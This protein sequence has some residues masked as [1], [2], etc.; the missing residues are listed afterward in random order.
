VSEFS[1]Q[2]TS[3]NNLKLNS[4]WDG[5]EHP[6]LG[7]RD[8]FVSAARQHV[9]NYYSAQVKNNDKISELSSSQPDT[10]LYPF[11]EMGQL[12]IKNDSIATKKLI[13]SA[14]PG[15]S[16]AVS[17]GYFN[18]TDQYSQSIINNSKATFNILMAHPMVSRYQNFNLIS[19]IVP[20]QYLYS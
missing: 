10:W 6:Y 17:T 4:V 7:N 9:W 1:L 16:L 2:L 14:P 20:I 13:E 12:G 11:I 8:K 15:A 5:K 18:L 3:E 19:T